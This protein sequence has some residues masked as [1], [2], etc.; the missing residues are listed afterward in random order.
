VTKYQY[1][2]LDRL[3]S[4]TDSDDNVLVETAYDQLGNVTRVASTNSVFNY[5]YDPLNRVTNAVCLLTNIP[6]FATVKYQIDYTFD[7]VG[8]VTN[9]VITGLQ[10]MSGVITTRYQY[11]V[12]N[13][14]T[15]VVQLTNAATTAS[16]WYSYDA[17]GRLWKKGYGNGDVVTHSYDPESRLLSLGIT[18]SSTPVWWWRYGWDHGGNILAITN[19]GTNV[20]LYG[21]DRA[22][23]LTNE[24]CLTN[25]LAG[26]ATNTWVYDEAGNWRAGDGR[27][28]LYN[29]D[30]ELAGIA[31]TNAP[32]SIPVTVTGEV[33]PGPNSNKW[34]NTR[35]RC[36]GVSAPVS[37]TDGTFS[38]AE[39]PLYPGTN[40][41]VVTVR[42]V[43]GN[44]A[45][46]VRTVS[47]PFPEMFHYDGNGNLT[48]WVCGTTNWAYEWDGADRLVRVRSNGVTQAQYWY[49]AHNRRI[50][51]TERVGGA[52]QR[53]LYLYDGWDIVAVMN[54]AGQ[55]RETFARG[56]GLAGDIGTLVAV[57]H[58]AGSSTNGVFYTQHNHRGDI[59]LTRAGTATVGRYGYSAFGILHSALGP[60]VCRFKF[61]SKE[62]DASTGFSYYGYRFYAPRW[63]RWLTRDPLRESAGLNLYS[64]C[65]NSPESYYDPDGSWSIPVVVGGLALWEYLCVNYALDKSLKEYPTDAQDKAQHCM[66]SC[67][68]NK[69]MGLGAPNVTLLAGLL[70]EVRPGGVFEWG[71]LVADVYGVIASYDLLQK[72]KDR[73]KCFA[74]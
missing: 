33:E 72:C 19:N 7:P 3:T 44:E 74:K 73:C 47:R 9:R 67:L 65:R 30:N 66:I 12:M 53:W 21:Y 31:S 38:L 8:N 27:W 37:Q 46:Q 16:A 10:G 4:V 13:R 54:E 36:R 71:D 49:D 2:S 63:Q 70:W 45:R 34:Y 68:H 50:A 35:V 43:S 20:N 24:V 62:R 51:K 60:D 48:N 41:L 28:R 15:N 14:L 61:S 42:D 5:T 56:A 23:Q 52:I 17:A 58:H 59:T 11:D 40:H 29:A 39:V 55:L 32:V 18:N 25:G 1:D 57:T 26:G 22:G 69:C 64:F 6:G